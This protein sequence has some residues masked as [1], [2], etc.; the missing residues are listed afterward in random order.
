MAGCR[1]LLRRAARW[2]HPSAYDSDRPTVL[3]VAPS[4]EGRITSMEVRNLPA[5]ALRAYLDVRGPKTCLLVKFER[6]LGVSR[7]LQRLRAD[8]IST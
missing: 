7:Q 6:R 3:S 8:R 4:Q 5:A 2:W 1:S